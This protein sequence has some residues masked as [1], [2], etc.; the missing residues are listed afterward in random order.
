MKKVFRTFCIIVLCLAVLGG[1]VA[2]GQNTGKGYLIVHFSTGFDDVLVE[3][4]VVDGKSP[5]VMPDDPIKS[6]Y[7]FLGWYYDEAHTVPFSIG[8]EPLE[9][10]QDLTLYADWHK[11]GGGSYEPVDS[12]EREGGFLFALQG[13]TYALVGYDG[14][15]KAIVVP[16]VYKGVAVTYIAKEA[17]VKGDFS[18]IT[19]GKGVTK[20]EDG[21]FRSLPDLTEL[22]VAEGNGH[23]VSE[24]GVLYSS[25]KTS[26]LRVPAKR[27]ESLVLPASV[28]GIADYA[29]EDCSIELSFADDGDYIG[30]D[31][32]D[33]AGFDGKVTIGK[34]IGVIRRHAFD[35]ATCEVIF[36]PDCGISSFPMQSFAGYAGESL[37]VPGTVKT[38][39]PYAFAECSAT[40]DLSG[41]GL[42]TLGKNVFGRY[43]GETLVVPATVTEIEQYAFVG[44][45]CRVTFAFGS[46]YEEVADYA[47]ADFGKA[48]REEDGQV[49]IKG[50]VVFSPSVKKVSQKA[51]VNA[52]AGVTFE[53]ARADVTFTGEIERFGGEMRFL[54]GE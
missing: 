4:L 16:A 37:V 53:N 40:V 46:Q 23:F 44:A 19:I 48:Q 8:Q 38:I 11:L 22:N 33:L 29:F 45:T 25:G 18:S 32:Y 39:E 28:K 47:F 52:V 35:R 15:G 12:N 2:C 3:D 34:K 50:E 49:T 6:G 31:S 14:E 43:A 17:F 54:R 27:T 9:I 21:A 51:F 5:A 30:I 20:I 24:D 41:T 13:N 10:T 36:A 7:D 1:L 26:L 42:V